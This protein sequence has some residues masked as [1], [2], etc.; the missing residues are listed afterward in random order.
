MMIFNT[1]VTRTPAAY[2]EPNKSLSETVVPYVK[3]IVAAIAKP[4]FVSESK[5]E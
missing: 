4:C 5:P 1:T 3:V 2:A